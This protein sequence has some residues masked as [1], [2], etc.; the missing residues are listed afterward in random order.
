M[1]T[2][3]GVVDILECEAM[4]DSNGSNTGRQA[5]VLNLASQLGCDGRGLSGRCYQVQ[6][7]L[8]SARHNRIMRP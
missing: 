1:T 3:T 2:A 5:L 4:D 8:I 6:D 7:K